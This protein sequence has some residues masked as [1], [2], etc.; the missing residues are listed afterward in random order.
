M[1]DYKYCV[2]DY[3]IVIILERP[4]LQMQKKIWDYSYNLWLE[5]YLGTLNTL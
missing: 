4:Y 2:F 3:G 5:W 1:D